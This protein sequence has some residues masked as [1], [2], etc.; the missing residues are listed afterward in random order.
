MAVR[1][2]IRFRV[3]I[4][5]AGVTHAHTH[6]Q[7]HSHFFTNEHTQKQTRPHTHTSPSKVT[8]PAR[9]TTQGQCGPGQ[10]RQGQARP[11][12]TYTHTPTHIPTHTRT[13]AHMPTHTQTQTHPQTTEFRT[14]FER[15]LNIFKDCWKFC[16]T[17]IE[18]YLQSVQNLDQICPRDLFEP[19]TARRLRRAIV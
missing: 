14:M 13:H 11:T 6:T 18:V 9:R 4:V 7:P 16:V 3:C 12:H 8:M 10:A 2:G 15:F 19:Q 17:L 1:K 5:K